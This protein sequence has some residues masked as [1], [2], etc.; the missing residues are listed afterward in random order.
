MSSLAKSHLQPGNDPASAYN[1]VTQYVTS[2][3]VVT[4][5]GDTVGIG[6]ASHVAAVDLCHLRRT[7]RPVSGVGPVGY[8]VLVASFRVLPTSPRLW[9][10]PVNYVD[11]IIV[12]SNTEQYFRIIGIAKCRDW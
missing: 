9:K 4:A 10:R 2:G 12:T 8:R 3:Y 11:N 5:D 1:R 7:G 6:S